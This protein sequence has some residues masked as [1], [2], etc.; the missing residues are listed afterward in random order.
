MLADSCS[1]LLEWVEAIELGIVFKKL[2]QLRGA[3]GDGSEID[4]CVIQADRDVS[5]LC[6][7]LSLRSFESLLTN[8]AGCGKKYA[9]FGVLARTLL[10]S[11]STSWK[12]VRQLYTFGGMARWSGST[13]ESRTGVVTIACL[14]L[15][16]PPTVEDQG[17]KP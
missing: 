8:R 4:K 12:A 17:S 3:T 13:H 5:Q 16:R 6:R 9:I 2:R 10:A 7:Y 1:L 14:S 11:L 15:L